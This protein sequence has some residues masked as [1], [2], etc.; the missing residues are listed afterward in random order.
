MTLAAVALWCSNR[1][2]GYRITFQPSSDDILA[3]SAFLAWTIVLPCSV[4]AGCQ[5]TQQCLQCRAHAAP[6]TCHV[7]AMYSHIT[8]RQSCRPVHM[9]RL[10]GSALVQVVLLSTSGEVL[11]CV[12]IVMSILL[13][14]KNAIS[15]ALRHTMHAPIG[16]YVALDLL[17]CGKRRSVS[18]TKI[19]G[20]SSS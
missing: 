15:T 3:A 2:P 5:G 16:Q 1:P 4:T 11:L 6:P 13:H 19:S 17:P 10:V 14:S 12:Y 20:V 9:R 8:A 18:T 7:A